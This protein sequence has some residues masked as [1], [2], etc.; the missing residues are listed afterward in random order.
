MPDKQALALRAYRLGC[1]AGSRPKD[2]KAQR[3]ALVAMKDFLA[4]ATP[5][6]LRILAS[7]SGETIE[8][9]KRQHEESLRAIDER[10]VNL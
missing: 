1:Y 6:E 2:K 8:E 9:T 7:L 4:A 10:L 3:R 5:D